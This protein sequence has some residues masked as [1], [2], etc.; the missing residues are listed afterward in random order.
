MYMHASARAKAPVAPFGG[1]SLTLPSPGDGPRADAQSFDLKSLLQ[2]RLEPLYPFPSTYCGEV[3]AMK[4]SAEIT[5][6]VVV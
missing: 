3:I 4:E 1:H 5:L 6:A 2:C